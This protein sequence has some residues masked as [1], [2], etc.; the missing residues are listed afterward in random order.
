MVL[1]APEQDLELR[2]RGK[3]CGN[4]VAKRGIGLIRPE[5]GTEDGAPDGSLA[6]I[7]ADSELNG[8]QIGDGVVQDLGLGDGFEKVYCRAVL[9]GEVQPLQG[10]V[11][12]SGP[13]PPVPHG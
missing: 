9:A 8:I 2:E 10:D 12:R 4:R 6:T 5:L 1:L 7:G 3:L 11:P 13:A